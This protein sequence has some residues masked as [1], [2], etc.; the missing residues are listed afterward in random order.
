MDD[1]FMNACL[2]GDLELTELILRI[3]L[4]RNDLH[5]LS[6]ESQRVMTNLVGR[7]I[8]LDIA[9]TDDAGVEYNI[10]I[11]Q[12]DSDANPRRS[13]YHSSV[14]D[15]HALKKNTPFKALPET[16]VILSRKTTSLKAAVR[17]ISSSGWRSKQGVP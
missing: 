2:G 10:E 7:S 9:A 13:R 11:Q 8:E 16:Y 15:A 14:I 6:V 5:V 12:A 1:I 3:V 4:D 17:S